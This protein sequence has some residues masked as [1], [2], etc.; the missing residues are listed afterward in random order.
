MYK[1]IIRK[2]EDEKKNH[3]LSFFQLFYLFGIGIYNIQDSSTL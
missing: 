1:G 2:I 3:M